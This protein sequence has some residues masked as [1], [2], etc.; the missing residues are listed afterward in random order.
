MA[1]PSLSSINQATETQNFRKINDTQKAESSRIS[2]P[3][4]VPANERSTTDVQE[5]QRV[6]APQ[7]SLNTQGQTVGATI[8]TTA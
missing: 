1:I 6:Q 2:T 3:G 8:N 5:K 7:K 4:A